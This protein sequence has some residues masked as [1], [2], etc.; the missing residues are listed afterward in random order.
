MQLNDQLMQDI[1]QCL[2]ANPQV[3]FAYLYGSSLTNHDVRDIDIAVFARDCADEFELAANLQTEL[4]HKTGL[5][6]DFF[7]VRVINSV[8]RHGDIF[9]LV[10]LKNVLQKGKVLVDNDFN[11]R[12]DFLNMFGSRYREC[13]GLIQEAIS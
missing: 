3:V 11:L 4:Y 8:S 9:G 10:Y 6:P 12:G 1:A 5:S 7:D 2:S 13:E